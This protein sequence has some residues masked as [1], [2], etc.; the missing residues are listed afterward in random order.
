MIN[1]DNL[2]GE[3]EN[4]VTKEGKI[5]WQLKNGHASDIKWVKIE[6]DEHQGP[7]SNLMADTKH[8]SVTLQLNS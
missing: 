2:G 6:W 4:G 3:I 1:S 7:E 5:V 8:E